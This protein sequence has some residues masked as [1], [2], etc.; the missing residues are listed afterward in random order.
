M[1]FE[2]RNR[3]T[4]SCRIEARPE[5]DLSFRR[6]RQSA[7]TTG[8]GNRY[9]RRTPQRA[10]KESRGIK[11]AHPRVARLVQCTG[12]AAT[13]PIAVPHDAAGG[14]RAM[15][16]DWTSTRFEPCGSNGRHR[17]LFQ[18]RRP[19]LARTMQTIARPPRSV[20]SDRSTTGHAIA[21]QSRWRSHERRARLDVGPT[22][23]ASPHQR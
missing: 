10:R 12:H 20:A 9:E 18:T 5:P 2:S 3:R 6:S 4:N 1:T 14:E 16:Q 11:I 13:L 8:L 22:G 15:I 17:T 23:A 7:V 19:C 21:R